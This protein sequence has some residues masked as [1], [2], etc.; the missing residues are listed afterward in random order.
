MAKVKTDAEFFADFEKEFEDVTPDTSSENVIPDNTEDEIEDPDE[1]LDDEVED[2][3][4]E[5]TDEEAEE[6]VESEDEVIETD[7]DDD[8][9][10][11]EDDTTEEDSN[12]V[13]FSSIAKDLGFEGEIKS[14]QAFLD[15]YKLSLEK[16][17]EDALQGV[18]DELKEA[19]SFAKEGGDYLSLLEV[20]SKNY[21]EVSNLDLVEASMERYFKTEDGSVD[22]EALNEWL[23]SK[24]S[25]EINMLGD[26]IRS[27]MK[28][29]QESKIQSIR[30]KARVEKEESDRKLKSHIDSLNV[31][32]GVKL[33]QS[34][35][36][37]LYNDTVTGEALKSLFY[38]NGKIS[39]A[40]LAENLFKIRKFEQAIHLAKVA[41]KTEGKRQVL[42]SATNSTVNRRKQKPQAEVKVQSPMDSFWSEITKKK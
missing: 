35:K 2:E 16:A 29:E 37:A 20:S 42:A 34:D 32:G 19:I 26:Q 24:S 18:P 10:V 40:K 31:I 14:K 5:G 9:I 4:A 12:S 1:G 3:S 7:E 23:D 21:D 11:F 17:K 22:R 15:S 13:D 39:Q 41:S 28:A 33:K 8:G 27:S 36:D 38:E 6:D 30:A 25:A